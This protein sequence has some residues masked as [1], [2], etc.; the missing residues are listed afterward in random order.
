[1]GDMNSI[2]GIVGVMAFACG[3]YCVYAYLKMKKDG[4]IN[5]TILL[6]KSYTERMCR[7]KD[8][9]LGKAAPAVLIL[10]LICIVYGIVDCIH[11]YVTP[12]GAVDAV[13]G[14]VFVGALVVFSVY[15]VRLRKEYFD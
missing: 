3:I 9:F 6:G 1:M 4:H 12:L 11:C 14:A 5:E 2:F 13:G 15:T 10:G 7:D 8:A